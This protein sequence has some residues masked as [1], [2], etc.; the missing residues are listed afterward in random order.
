MSLIE[1]ITNRLAEEYERATDTVAVSAIRL[2]RQPWPCHKKQFLL[3]G[4]ESSGTTIIA[5][6]LFRGGSLRFFR[7]G[8]DGNEW[9]WQ[10]Y[11]EIYQGNKTIRDYPHLQLYDAVKVPG[12]AAIL[13]HYVKEFPNVSVICTVR[14]PRDMVVSACKTWGVKERAGLADI[15]WVTESWLGI[16]EKDPVARLARRWRIYLE[17]TRLVPGVIYV[18]YE[19]F[20]ADKVGCILRLAAELNIDVDEARIQELCNQQAS[21]PETRDY[22][23]KG[24]GAWREGLLTERD[25]VVIEEIC[26]ELMETWNYPLSNV[27]GQVSSSSGADH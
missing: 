24:P 19:D 14:D 11:Q 18:R 7:E 17:Q 25:I 10:A 9:C 16:D 22:R 6:L 23:P 13:P 26:G 12:F 1:R 27:S 8:K 4:S 2:R 15:K 21:I 5:R 20:C 3:V